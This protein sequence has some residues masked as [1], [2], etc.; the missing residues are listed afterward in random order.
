MVIFDHYGVFWQKT[1]IGFLDNFHFQNDHPRAKKSYMEK[2]LCQVI[3]GEFIYAMRG[4][5]VIDPERLLQD[6]ICF[7]TKKTIY[8]CEKNAYLI[9]SV[10]S[11]GLERVSVA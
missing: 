11:L 2:F 3:V 1:N 6:Y 4:F 10:A 9:K 5:R 8:N 7:S